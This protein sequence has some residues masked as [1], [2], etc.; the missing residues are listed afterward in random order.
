[1]V[2]KTRFV[3]LKHGFGF[4]AEHGWNKLV[5]Q[6]AVAPQHSALAYA[7]PKSLQVDA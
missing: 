5:P 1:M 4:L 6:I 2:S 7:Q 3:C